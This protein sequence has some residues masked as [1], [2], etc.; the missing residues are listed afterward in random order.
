M[1]FERDKK[2]VVR[3]IT[4]SIKSRYTILGYVQFHR[5][6]EDILKKVPQGLSAED[7]KAAQN[8]LLRREFSGR[9]VIIDEAH[10]LRDSP[11]EAAEDDADEEAAAAAAP[12]AAAAG[13]DVDAPGGDTELAESKA[14]KRLTPSLL[15]VLQA[16]EGM[17]L[18]LATATPM[19]NSYKEILFLLNMLLINDKRDDR[20]KLSEAQIF[21]PNGEFRKAADGTP[22]GEQLL[23][24][25]ASAYVS[26]MR[27]ENPLS[28]PVRL[29]PQGV[30]T[31]ESWP[32][33]SPLGEGISDDARKRMGGLPFVPV[34]FEG[35]S[36]AQYE[37]ISSDA[38]ESGGV[39]ISSIDE[40]VQAGNWL[41]PGEEGVQ[42]RDLGF[43]SCFEDS[44]PPLS[45]IHI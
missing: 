3:A 10:N 17:K 11:A 7:Q 43:D 24:A 9:L 23:G 15:R 44:V 22:V 5:Y 12:A 33:R 39:G 8:R 41:F 1:E 19:Y 27:G 26:F 42:I 2:T 29:P 38:I 25:V 18:I 16:A 13:E 21:L 40:M 32:A 36:A 30:E 34:H 14:G 28:F 35:P 37:E 6:I 20:L 4:E 45:L 31:L